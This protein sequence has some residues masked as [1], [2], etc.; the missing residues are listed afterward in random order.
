VGNGLAVD[1]AWLL[2]ALLGLIVVAAAALATRRYWL[3][4]GGGTVECGL[5][6]PSGRGGW[7]LGVVSYQRDELHWHGAFGV[8]LRPEHVLPRRSAKVTSRRPVAES[9]GTALDPAW[10]VVEVTT[11]PPGGP[12]ELAMSDEAL[13]GLLAWLEASPPGSHLDDLSL[14]LM[15]P[16]ER[17]R[18]IRA[19]A[20]F[21][22]PRSSGW[23][24]RSG[25]CR[26]STG[27][28]GP[29]LEPGWAN[30]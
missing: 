11:G 27:T 23:R 28:R 1:A 22:G 6:S 29:H 24:K 10:M 8:G 26:C 14:C 9:E 18:R 12:V 21:A 13:T 17:S 4:R 25:R 2:A 7:R 15:T 16:A 3:E 20:R 30:P 5:R 19:V